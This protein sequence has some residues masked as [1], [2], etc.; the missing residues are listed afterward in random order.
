MYYTLPMISQK[1]I[2]A[3]SAELIFLLHRSNG[4]ERNQMK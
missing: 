2:V 4:T 1:D 3:S